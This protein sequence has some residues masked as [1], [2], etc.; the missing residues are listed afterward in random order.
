MF[1]LLACARISYLSGLNTY[2]HIMLI[3]RGRIIAQRA[4]QM[5]L[6]RMGLGHYTDILARKG[7][8]SIADLERLTERQLKNEM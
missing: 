5:L 6:V 1:A 2:T 4:T 7:Y 3:R 8:I